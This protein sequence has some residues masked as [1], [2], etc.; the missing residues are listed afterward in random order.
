M[1]LYKPITRKVALYSLSALMLTGSFLPTLTVYAN[2]PNDIILTTQK[3]QAEV[4]MSK[5][6]D[7]FQVLL[8]KELDARVEYGDSTTLPHELLANTVAYAITAKHLANASRPITTM[9]RAMFSDMLKDTR[10][11][12]PE[13]GTADYGTVI[14]TGVQIL[15]E[16]Y[17]KIYN[18]FSTLSVVSDTSPPDALYNYISSNSNYIYNVLNAYKTIYT[19]NAKYPTA[20]D[21]ISAEAI[22]NVNT[23]MDSLYEMYGKINQNF[24]ADSLADSV[25]LANVKDIKDLVNDNG[26]LHPFYVLGVALSSTY[27]PFMTDLSSE[28]TYA[29][30]YENLATGDVKKV[31][32]KIALRKPLYA[33]ISK[34]SVIDN[35]SGK[36]FSGKPITLQ[37]FLDV[38]ANP[39]VQM[40][41]TLRKDTLNEKTYNNT[42]VIDK[43]Q[44][45]SG[46][47]PPSGETETPLEDGTQAPTDDNVGSG[48][49][50]TQTQTVTY[51]PNDYT[52]PVY[53]SGLV[54]DGQISSKSSSTKD[55][56]DYIS[57][58]RHFTRVSNFNYALM[59]NLVN[60]AN[61]N[62]KIT[63]DLNR[64]I[65]MDMFGNIVTESGI[66]ILPSIANTTNYNYSVESYVG[67]TD[68]ANTYKNYV[69]PENATFKIAYPY[70][71]SFSE[72]LTEV[73][74]TFNNKF[75]FSTRNENLTSTTDIS[76]L[77][78]FVKLMD[79]N[80]VKSRHK[81]WFW[82]DKTLTTKEPLEYPS[83]PLYPYLIGKNAKDESSNR[84]QLINKGSF[85]AIH[86]KNIIAWQ[87]SDKDQQYILN[88]SHILLSNQ[89]GDYINSNSVG[90]NPDI[91]RAMYDLNKA[92]LT[93]DKST[94][95]MN[96]NIKHNGTLRFSHMEELAVEVGNGS[97]DVNQ[98]L[99]GE[100]LSNLNFKDG[101]QG[102]S[103]SLFGGWGESLHFSITDSDTF[104]TLLY[105]PKID[106]IPLLD[107]IVALFKPLLVVACVL[108]LFALVLSWRP[109]GFIPS[110]GMLV[111]KLLLYITVVG[112][113]FK[114]MPT[115]IDYAINEPVTRL[116][117]NMSLQNTMLDLEVKEKAT[118][119]S[120]FNSYSELDT[121]QGTSHIVLAELDME[122]YK[123]IYDMVY[124]G[125]FMREFGFLNYFNNVSSTKVSNTMY[126][127]GNELR[128]SLDKVF[129]SSSIKAFNK[130]TMGEGD[131]KEY[132]TPQLKQYWYDPSELHYFTPYHLMT[133]HLLHVV[134]TVSLETN[135][136]VFPLEYATS[137][138]MTGFLRN[139]L[140]SNYYLKTSSERMHIVAKV[141]EDLSKASGVE[142][143]SYTPAEGE[144]FETPAHYKSVIDTLV[145]I[146]GALGTN[147]DFLGI[148]KWSGLHTNSDNEK[149]FGRDKIDD[150]EEENKIFGTEITDGTSGGEA[151]ENVRDIDRVKTTYWYSSPYFSKARNQLALVDSASKLA[152]GEVNLLINGKSI[153][154]PVPM[155]KVG[156]DTKFSLYASPHTLATGVPDVKYSE[157]DGRGVIYTRDTIVE[158]DYPN[159]SADSVPV[160]TNGAYLGNIK[161]IE[162]GGKILLA[163]DGG[164]SFINAL[165]ADMY[166]NHEYN[167]AMVFYPECN[168][169]NP[170]GDFYNKVLKV[171]FNTKKFM[172]TLYPMSL[173]VSDE[174]LIK[175]IALQATINFNNEFSA[176]G[177]QLHPQQID[178]STLNVDMFLKQLLV[179][180][181]ELARSAKS[182][183]LYNYVATVGG[184]PSIMALMLLEICLAMSVL[185][186]NS[187]LAFHTVVLP[188]LFLLYYIFA[189]KWMYEPWKGTLTCFIGVAVVNTLTMAGL[190]IPNAMT[191]KTTSGVIWAI[192]I[193]ALILA[194]SIVAYGFLWYF[195]FKDFH[196][197]GFVK[198]K[199]MFQKAMNKLSGKV[200]FTKSDRKKAQDDAEKEVVSDRLDDVNKISNSHLST[201][202]RYQSDLSDSSAKVISSRL[203]LNEDTTTAGEVSTEIAKQDR[204]NTTPLSDRIDSV[205]SVDYKDLSTQGAPVTRRQLTELSGY[206]NLTNGKD[207]RMIGDTPFITNPSVIKDQDL[208]TAYSVVA[209]VSKDTLKTLSRDG[210]THE[211]S[212]GMVRYISPTADGISNQTVSYDNGKLVVPSNAIK[213]VKDY[214]KSQDVDFKTSNNTISITNKD[215]FTDRVKA[216]V[217]T[218]SKPLAVKT[219]D[220]TKYDDGFTHNDTTLVSPD[221]A[222]KDIK[223]MGNKAMKFDSKHS[224]RK[225]STINSKTVSKMFKEDQQVYT[226]SINLE[227]SI[228]GNPIVQDLYATANKIEQSVARD[229]A[230]TLKTKT[231]VSVVFESKDDYDKFKQQFTTSSNVTDY[232]VKPIVHRDGDNVTVYSLQGDTLKAENLTLP[233]FNSSEYAMR[234]CKNI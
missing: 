197:L 203:S 184:V 77:N 212:N 28:S 208:Q 111:V 123:G 206:Y 230:V 42:I 165:N 161:Y 169:V 100:E 136:R 59:Y 114:L 194:V 181:I 20:G 99:V 180:D 162:Q 76:N 110:V 70:I 174:N 215:K 33:D 141:A 179:P 156:D 224:T 41:L 7:E 75:V 228:P 15:S 14:T 234:D 126:L 63:N 233:E 147:Q 118:K 178:L 211:I 121:S 132:I 54:K 48:P 56:E 218:L 193:S 94:G 9:Y 186:R 135:G 64:P 168:Y 81:G 23:M 221:S 25:A 124:G 92:Y 137:Y 182:H 12:F 185:L 116:Y 223:Q 155:V 17:T 18:N 153:E 128:M 38:F 3:N 134:N 72:Q 170:I 190:L 122:Q 79:D 46:E 113:V 226:Y 11:F 67:K 173:N 195:I 13:L 44:E 82:T 231:G 22:T 50:N 27:I 95:D 104:G 189:S 163:V 199:G 31:K 30:L 127:Q 152:D 60:N 47:T 139:Y 49:A 145:R 172:D 229:K 192:L 80:D 154:Q 34:T 160:Y 204:V 232:F 73:K 112:A 177:Y 159:K 146:D 227:N 107:Q 43:T 55:G 83:F 29:L 220:D 86:T 200:S 217:E 84:K 115:F 108:G 166:Y 1:K 21:F 32:D 183:S 105:T 196:N 176:S 98:M 164:S 37:Q 97:K 26:D 4:D 101:D 138:K 24:G 191:S 65:C 106:E 109:F 148:M 119:T 93:I 89:E 45:S 91:D 19:Y 133:E 40:T 129:S 143:G 10:E 175:A 171:N 144:S 117:G 74:D 69:F 16:E 188:I 102:W 103:V 187:L 150:I 90:Q 201:I 51:D 158:V 209:P 142:D 58:D 219:K 214:L 96:T 71:D 68:P 53:I 210:I 151:S 205:D 61:L 57:R 78:Y 8:K 198:A 149:P 225:A 85:N 52:E 66:I 167:T 140:K 39:D 157:Q 131:R 202:Q 222:L 207:Y 6:D 5:L 35:M 125:D 2:R 130:P 62:Q 87:D 216:E 36:S 213:T 120:F 88:L